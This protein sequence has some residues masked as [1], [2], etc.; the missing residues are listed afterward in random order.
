VSICAQFDSLTHSYA[1]AH[2]SVCHEDVIK[3]QMNSAFTFLLVFS[4]SNMVSDIQGMT[5]FLDVSEQNTEENV[6]TYM[7]GNELNKRS[8]HHSITCN[9]YRYS[10][11]LR[12]MGPLT[13][14]ISVIH[15]RSRAY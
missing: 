8:L 10:I 4:T 12:E 7:G 11:Q 1:F 15:N 2:L 13:L 3:K 14:I 6:W 5:I 9:L